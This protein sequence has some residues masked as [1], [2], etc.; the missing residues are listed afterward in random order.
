MRL[1]NWV[2]AGMFL[3]AA[4]GSALA[5]DCE[6]LTFDGDVPLEAIEIGPLVE[7]NWQGTK[8]VAD[9]TLCLDDGSDLALTCRRTL[10]QKRIDKT[11]SCE[12]S[13]EGDSITI[14]DSGGVADRIEW[15]I[16]AEDDQGN[17]ASTTCS[18]IVVN[19]GNN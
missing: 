15:T 10:K 11:K 13:F 9:A 4:A 1:T 16:S 19:P 7:A 2:V 14:L 3:V 17:A 8:F 18:V 5:Q 12:V 6:R